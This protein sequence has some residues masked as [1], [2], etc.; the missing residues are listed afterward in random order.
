MNSDT[1]VIIPVYN[2]Q[3]Q[4]GTVLKGLVKSYPLV[5]CVDDGSTD[6]SATEIVKYG[7]VLV[8]HPINLGQGAA[9]QTGI[10]YALKLIKV[11]YFV[12]FDADGQ[13]QVS[14]IAKM[15][16]LLIKKHADIVLGSRFLGE[17][18]SLPRRKKIVL[19]AGVKF[20]NIMTGLKVTD[21]HNGLRVFNRR[22]AKSLNLEMYD[23]SHASEILDKISKYKYK[24][25]EAPV[26]IKYTDYSKRKGQ[27]TSNAVNIG[28]DVIINRFSK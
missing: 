24:Y 6:D 2:E 27:S 8:Q 5:I 3:G 16:T 21:T 4:I 28:L 20:T 10:E 12:T 26:T 7:G 15:R 19:K 1:A 13:H 14:D 17:V 9:L 18:V 11:K 23:F 25:V 22:V